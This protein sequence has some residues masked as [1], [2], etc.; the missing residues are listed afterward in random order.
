M[1]V[2]FMSLWAVRRTAEG[3]T[4]RADSTACPTLRELPGGQVLTGG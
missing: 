4:K 3:G 2:T 1:N